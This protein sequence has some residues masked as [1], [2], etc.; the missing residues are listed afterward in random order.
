MSKRAGGVSIRVHNIAFWSNFAFQVDSEFWDLLDTSDFCSPTTKFVIPSQNLQSHNWWGTWTFVPGHS[1][2]LCE[3][4]AHLWGFFFDG[5]IVCSTLRVFLFWA[6]TLWILF[7]A[8]IICVPITEPVAWVTDGWPP[9]NCLLNF[10]IFTGGWIVCSTLRFL[11]MVELF[12]QLCEFFLFWPQ[13]LFLASMICVPIREHGSHLWVVC[14]TLRVFLISDLSFE[15]KF[16]NL[17]VAQTCPKLSKPVH[18]TPLCEF[19]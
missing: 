5:W 18:K 11:L 6:S 10:E 12:A 15:I 14:S 1:A 4:F 17:K 13:I 7:L 9:V 8:S 2:S 19:F 16:V 3:L